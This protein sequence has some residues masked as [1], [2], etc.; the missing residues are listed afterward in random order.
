MKYKRIRIIMIVFLII[1]FI[2]IFTNK[3]FASGLSDIF[4]GA[5][6]FL[7]QGSSEATIDETVLQEISSQ[8]YNIL[9]T[10]GTIIVLVVGIIIG[11]KLMTSEA[12]NKAEAKKSLVVFVVGSVIVFGSFGIWKTLVNVV[13]DLDSSVTST[14]PSDISWGIIEGTENVSNLTN[15][16]LKAEFNK[17]LSSDIT[18]KMSPRN[19]N[20]VDTVQEAVKQ[21]SDYKQKIYNECKKRGLLND[22]G[23][24]LKN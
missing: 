7:S 24:G 11:I 2:C 6:S 17:N 13:K 20:K 4:S 18:E 21:M 15:D 10:L 1:A 5:D 16:Q 8:I 23:T 3:V 22:S 14:S 9:L 19:P 12:E